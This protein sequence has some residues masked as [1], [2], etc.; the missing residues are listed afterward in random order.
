MWIQCAILV[1]I[2]GQAVLLYKIIK[3]ALS[4]TCLLLPYIL[5]VK[6][7]AVHGGKPK[8]MS[9]HISV[10]NAWV[11]SDRDMPAHVLGF[12]T[13]QGAH[14]ESTMQWTCRGRRERKQSVVR[15]TKVLLDGCITAFSANFPTSAGTNVHMNAMISAEPL[16]YLWK[17]YLQADAL[18]FVQGEW[19]IKK[20]GKHPDHRGSLLRWVLHQ[21]HDWGS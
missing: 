18:R 11:N 3:I 17:P 2:L 14:F 5:V 9:R 20:G 7:L 16:L 6:L 4:Q 13:M 1:V 19:V 15:G 10:S 8:H 21:N 12:A